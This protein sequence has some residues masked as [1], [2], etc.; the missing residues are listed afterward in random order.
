MAAEY[1]TIFKT[2]AADDPVLAEVVRR[3]VEAY[4]PERSIFSVPLRAATLARTATMTCS[5]WFRTMRPP[6][7]GAAVWLMRCFAG[8]GLPPTCWSAPVP[9]LKIAGY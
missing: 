1:P 5:W 9:I 7:D 4:L 8:R 2:P 3:L 6:S